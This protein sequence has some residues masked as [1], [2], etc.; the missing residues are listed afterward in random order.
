[1]VLVGASGSGKSTW[2]TDN[3]RAGQVVASDDLRALV[4]EDRFDQ[5]AGK[6]AFDILDL[7]LERRARRR[8]LTVVDTLG[9]DVARRRQYLELA[10]GHQMPCFAV[11]FETPAKLCRERNSRRSRP[12]PPAVLSSQL[13]AMDGMVA[14]LEQEGFDGVFAPSEVKLV[15]AALANAQ[16]MAARQREDAM[17]MRFG[18]QIPSFTWPGGTAELP[19]RLGE[20]ATA[21]EDAGV[22]SLHVMDHFLQIPQVG[23]HFDEM[24]ESY[25]TLSYL[26]ARTQRARLGA[27]V[28]GVTYRNPAHLAKIV[29]TLD[30]LSAGRAICGIGAAWFAREHE[31]YGWRFPPVRERFEL[32]EDA[33]QLLPLMWGPGAPAFEGKHI[34]LHEA[35]CYPRP[36]Q[37]RVP[38]MVGG[39]GERKT[40]RLVAQYADA[41]NLFGDAET[42]RHKVSVLHKHCE[43]VDRPPDEIEVTHLGTVLV[44]A[45]DVQLEA[46]V[47]ALRPSGVSPEAF[48]ARVNAG[49][50]EDLIGHFRNLAEAGVQTAIVNM[51]DVHDPEALGRLGEVI[52][53]FS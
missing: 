53:A 27:L 39:G 38:I 36:V 16:A 15:P 5:R 41:C 24:L 12:V 25:A 35:V 11:V 48:A 32:L 1:V 23:R 9:I 46:K 28:T 49:T 14:S 44:A 42:V 26:A 22:T 40:L 19:T 20:V 13:K 43:V 18:L 3:F 33:L 21:A 52:A 29:A 8:L 47:E 6:D 10:R 37:D 2:A 50:V 45:D 7:V 31:A 17:G 30:V 34:R 4:G 51:P